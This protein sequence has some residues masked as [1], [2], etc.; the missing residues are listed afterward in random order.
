M[1]GEGG[2]GT[3]VGLGD[4]EGRFASAAVAAAGVPEA[5]GAVAAGGR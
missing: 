1:A 3:V 4:L 2:E 5:D